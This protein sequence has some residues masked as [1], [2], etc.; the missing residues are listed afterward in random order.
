VNSQLTGAQQVFLT[1]AARPEGAAQH[2]GQAPTA[3]SLHR[4]GMIRRDP[5]T[6]RWH[7]TDLGRE[8]L[9][10]EQ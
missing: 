10:H 1:F 4:R 2:N 5:T 6:H 8:A 9:R 7:T 3:T